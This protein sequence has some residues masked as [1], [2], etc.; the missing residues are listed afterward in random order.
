MPEHEPEN[1]IDQAAED[2]TPLLPDWLSSRRQAELLNAPEISAHSRQPI[3]WPVATLLVL[4]LIASIVGGI[5]VYPHLTGQA[6]QHPQQPVSTSRAVRSFQDFAVPTAA[7]KPFDITRGPDGNLWFTEFD[8]NKIARITPS[9]VITEYALPTPGAGPYIIVSGPDGNLWFTEYYGD[10]IGRVTPDGTIT[11]FTLSD[12]NSSAAGVAAGP[13]G[14][15]WVTAYPG[16][17]YRV[18]PSG[19]MTMYLVPNRP[20]V[21]FA[22]T[23]GPDGNLW[24]SYDAEFTHLNTQNDNLIGR[25]TPSGT[26]ST[27]PLPT[28]GSNVDS[29]TAGPDGNLWFT[30][31]ANELIGSISPTGTIHEYASPTPYNSLNDI[32]AGPDGAL[33]FTQQNGVIGRMTPAG[34]I[35]K[36]I[37]PIPDSQPDGIVA[38]PGKTIWYTEMEADRIGCITL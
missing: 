33:W 11:E 1:S 23:A 36:F 9:G 17:I 20:T 26:V 29:I 18:T 28:T 15:L 21:P 13:D 38:G 10:K 19:S 31:Y 22:I 30:D 5:A 27:F 16:E 6:A 4:L 32:T 35:S 14:N 7:S 3:R 37:V 2:Q 25:I 24:F 34:A 12:P 8:G